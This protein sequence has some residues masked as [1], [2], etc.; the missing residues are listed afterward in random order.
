MAIAGRFGYVQ[1]LVILALVYGLLVG[2][3]GLVMAA[4]RRDLL[5]KRHLRDPGSAW[6]EADSAAPDLERAKLTT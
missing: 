2:P 5:N 3:V 1:T 6:Q 4:A